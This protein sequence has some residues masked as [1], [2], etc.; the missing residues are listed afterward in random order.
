MERD[1]YAEVQQA[2]MAANEALDHLAEAR[3]EL[4]RA[5]GWGIADMLGGGFFVSIIKQ[6]HLSR[7]QEELEAARACLGRLSRG[8]AAMGQALPA[9]VEVGG[10]LGLTDLLLDNVISDWLVQA[11]IDEAKHAVERAAGEVE[12]ARDALCRM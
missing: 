5:G 7:A 8:F 12:R 11:R 1:R 2:V 9:D 10:F 4:G 6:G 3:R